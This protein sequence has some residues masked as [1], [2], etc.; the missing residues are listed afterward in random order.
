MQT[1]RAM[2]RQTGGPSAIE[3]E[4]V[5]LPDPGEDQVLVEHTA[6][7]LNFIDTYVRSGLYP[8][9]LPS[10][11]G[12]EAAGR[13]VAAGAASGFAEGERVA[14]FG[15]APGTY[16]THRIYPAKDLFRLS[17]GV[18]DEVAA[19]ALLKGCTAEFLI[20]RCARVQAGQTVLVHAAAG[21]VGQLL[22]QWLK[23]I[24]ATVIGTVSSAAKADAAS[25]AGADHVVRYDSVDVAEAVLAITDGAGVD[26]S[27]D[28]VGRSTWE[29]SLKS[30]RR[31]GLIVSF[32]NASG[33]VTDVA[34]GTLSAHGSLFVT[35]PGLYHY[36]AEPEERAAGARRLWQ[37][38]EQ[39]VLSVPIGQRYSLREAAAAH[40]DLEA[41]GTMGS[42]ILQP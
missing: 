9:A 10:G 5:D 21:G 11:L 16:A 39:G 29:A 13:V 27:L 32:G 15:P 12:M 34:L 3:W 22:V 18:T 25:N 37:L 35:R 30:V 26:V 2:L 1:T 17:G 6:I 38:I 23:H 41:R 28:G 14:T 7:G 19:A 24:G 8:A 33:P 20:E 42:T 36:Y 31:R 4:T 40:R